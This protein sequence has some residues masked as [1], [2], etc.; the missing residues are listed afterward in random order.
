MAARIVANAARWYMETGGIY[1]FYDAKDE[2]HPLK[3]PRKSGF[4]AIND[5]GFSLGVPVALCNWLYG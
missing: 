5:Y 4:G 1:E 2:I 3:L